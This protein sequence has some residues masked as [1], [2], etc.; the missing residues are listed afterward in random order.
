VRFTAQAEFLNFMN[1]PVFAPGSYSIS[2]AS[3]R[4]TS[5]VRVGA[6]KVQLRGYLR[7]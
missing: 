1:Q 7:W 4:Q 6:R 5:N 3:F 2:S